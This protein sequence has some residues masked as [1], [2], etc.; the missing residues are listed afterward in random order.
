V[1]L[2]KLK[3]KAMFVG[4]WRYKFWY[5]EVNHEFSFQVSQSLQQCIIPEVQLP[6][7]TIFVKRFWPK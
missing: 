6:T 5:K 4:F 2:P 1:S 7:L 3:I